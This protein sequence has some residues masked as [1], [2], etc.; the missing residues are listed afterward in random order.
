MNAVA[1]FPRLLAASGAIDC[2]IAVGLG[3]WAMH[4]AVS[5]HDQQR[6]AIAALFLFLHG[7][8]LATLAPA[9]GSRLRQTGLGL[10]LAATILFSGSLAC[11][12]VFGIEPRLAPIGGSSAML[13]WLL[14]AAG[15]VRR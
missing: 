15:F 10:L 9:G 3:A 1:P 12:A 7:L 13:G 14:V 11:A 8:A 2:S 4:A 5:P 6:L